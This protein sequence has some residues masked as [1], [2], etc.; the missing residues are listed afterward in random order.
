MFMSFNESL[1]Q[2]LLDCVFPSRLFLINGRP[3]V[4]IWRETATAWIH[5]TLRSEWRESDNH[6][7][8]TGPVAFEFSGMLDDGARPAPALHA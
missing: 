8:M 6:V 3:P 5:E 4:H 7:L 2:A 1:T